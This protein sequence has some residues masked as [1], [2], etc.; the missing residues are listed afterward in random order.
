MFFDSTYD[1]GCLFRWFAASL[2]VSG[3]ACGIPGPKLLRPLTP[4]GDFVVFMNG[5]TPFAQYRSE[6]GA[7]LW[8]LDEHDDASRPQQRHPFN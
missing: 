2:V 1:Q 3:C 5:D 4:D 6:R 8:A 7:Q